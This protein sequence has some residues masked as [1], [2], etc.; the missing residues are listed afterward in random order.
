[1]PSN[2]PTDDAAALDHTSDEAKTKMGAWA[3]ERLKTDMI[4][5]ADLKIKSGRFDPVRPKTGGGK[6]SSKT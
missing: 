5:N 6:A 1:M 2:Q 3:R 4:R